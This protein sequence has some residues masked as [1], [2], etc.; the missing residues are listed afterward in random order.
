MATPLQ[1]RS[2]APKA[3]A[4]APEVEEI[5]VTTVIG[6]SIRLKGNVQGDE[7]LLVLGRVDGMLTL[8]KTL[9][10]EESGIVKANVSVRN[11][12]I[13]GVVVGNI[14][15][16]DSVEILEGGRVVGDIKAPRV[17]I[18]DGALFSGAVDMGKLNVPQ[19]TRPLGSAVSETAE[20]EAAVTAVRHLPSDGEEVAFEDSGFGALDAARRLRKKVIVK[21]A[22]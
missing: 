11:A 13:S 19:A 9:S 22:P 1:T 14:Q 21:R 10:V 20:G 18:M 4:P 2:P 7:D 15:A 16:S 5:E 3:V 17:I 12:I 6:S 8:S